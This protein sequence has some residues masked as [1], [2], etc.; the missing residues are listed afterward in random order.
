MYEDEG[1]ELSQ[2]KEKAEKAR[3]NLI[4]KDLSGTITWSEFVS[5]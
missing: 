4:D 5:V 1:E 2:E 3:F